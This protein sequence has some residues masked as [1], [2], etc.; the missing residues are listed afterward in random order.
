MWFAKRDEI[1][2]E[3]VFV[4]RNAKWL[5]VMQYVVGLWTSVFFTRSICDP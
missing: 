4:G 1:G 5:V 2:L 3:D